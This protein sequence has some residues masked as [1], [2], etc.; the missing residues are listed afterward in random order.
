[1]IFKHCAR[2]KKALQKPVLRGEKGGG[3]AA[4]IWRIEQ[5]IS[6]QPC[7]KSLQTEVLMIQSE[8]KIMSAFQ[9]SA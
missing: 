7:L 9:G 2:G 1:M 3:A 4:S 6:H 5:A 8:M